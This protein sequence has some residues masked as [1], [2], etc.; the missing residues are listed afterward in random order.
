MKALRMIRLAVIAA[1]FLSFI[2][3]FSC[4]KKGDPTLKTFEKPEAPASL[5]AMHREGAIMLQ[6]HYERSREAQ[7]AEFIVLRSTGSDFEKLSHLEKT[8]RKFVDRDIREGTTYRYKVIAQSFRGVYSNASPVAEASPVPSPE[9]PGSLSYTVSGT[10]VTLSWSPRNTGDKFNV[11]KTA[12]K[13]SYGLTPL[14]PAP[15]SEPSF[16]DTFSVNKIVYYTVRSLTGSAIRDEGRPSD[17]LRFDP[18]DLTPS[19]PENVEAFPASD[20]VLLTWTASPEPWVTGY[21][22]YRRIGDA[23]Y[24]P[25][26]KTQ[27]PTFVDMDAAL[28]RRDYRITAVGPA[29]ESSSAEI[30]NI[31]YTPQR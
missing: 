12:E 22:I 8:Q 23:E 6:W 2:F 17:E 19:P 27:I 4:G 26:G 30:T 14:N 29:K 24:I 7:I 15:L 21:R 28:S 13:G 3:L 16:T 25:I 10:T 5:T 18:A 20:R 11:Y 9:P 1:S 31:I